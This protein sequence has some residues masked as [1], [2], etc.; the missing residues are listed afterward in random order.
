MTAVAVRE[1]MFQLAPR[2]RGAAAARGGR[3]RSRRV[4]DD[5]EDEEE[6]SEDEPVKK[7]VRRPRAASLKSPG[8]SEFTRELAP[9]LSP[10]SA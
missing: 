10:L 8:Y 2:R 9:L 3:R 6:E 4:A 5:S 7:P 1:E